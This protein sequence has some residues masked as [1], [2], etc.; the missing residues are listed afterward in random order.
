[1]QFRNNVLF[2]YTVFLAEGQ[3]TLLGRQLP[4]HLSEYSRYNLCENKGQDLLRFLYIQRHQVEH[5]LLLV[6]T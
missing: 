5:L 3:M 2:S 6:Q 1:M 4:R